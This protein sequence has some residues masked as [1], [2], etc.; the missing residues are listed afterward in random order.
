[1]CLCVV[2]VTTEVSEELI[3]SIIRVE[4]ISELGTSK[5]T[6]DY[7]EISDYNLTVEMCSSETSVS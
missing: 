4:R 1:M 7:S 6:G 5:I 2:L 3:S